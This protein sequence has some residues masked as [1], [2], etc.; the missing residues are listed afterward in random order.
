MTDYDDFDEYDLTGSN[1]IVGVD[2]T[3]YLVQG[4]IDDQITIFRDVN[5]LLECER[6]AVQPALLGDKE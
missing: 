2:N 3:D 1:Y 6:D 4:K 5:K